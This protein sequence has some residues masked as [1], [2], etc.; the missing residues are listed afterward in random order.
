MKVVQSC[1]TL[2]DPLDCSPSGF[3][4]HGDSLGK[5]TGVGSHAL[6]QGIFP[7]QG[8]NPGLPHCRQVTREVLKESNTCQENVKA[9]SAEGTTNEGLGSRRELCNSSEQLTFRSSSS[10]PKSVLTACPLALKRPLC[11]IT[12]ATLRDLGV[13]LPPD[14]Q[15]QRGQF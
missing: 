7:T 11:Y 4:V 3:S 14:I 6:L 1:L 10:R 5:N 8:S 2:R 9:K 12:A 15:S 13:F